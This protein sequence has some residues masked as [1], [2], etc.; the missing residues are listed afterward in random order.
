MSSALLAKRFALLAGSVLMLMYVLA[1]I[2]W[3][4]SSSL[5]RE[6]DITSIPPHWIPNPPTFA[7]FKAIIDAGTGVTST[8]GN[9]SFVPSTAEYLL[10]ALRNSLIVASAVV[11]LNLLVSIPAAYAMA[12][13]RYVGRNM[14]VYFMLA[15]RVIPDIALVVPFFLFVRK[16]GLLDNV[17]ALIITYLAITIPFSVFMLLSYFESLPDELDKA[18]RV[19]GCSRVQSLIKVFLPLAQPSLVAV[20]MFTF[21]TSWNEFLFA[22]M[23]TQTAASQTVPIIVASFTSDFTTSFSFINAAG[24][25]A[26]VP[27][28]IIAVV[29]E[30]YI[31]SGLSAGAVKG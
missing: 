10:P 6:A 21:L 27:P 30:R 4:L 26:I 2:A 15:T 29:F 12:K 31:V 9:A 17:G 16:L 18:A 3:L 11:V 7:S 28:V 13:I 20:I 24:V 5:Q 25:V 19:D 1:P 22:L 14:S 23:F 8:E